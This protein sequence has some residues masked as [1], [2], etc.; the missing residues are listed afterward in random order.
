[1]AYTP[2]KLS[3][4]EFLS[5]SLDDQF[6]LLGYYNQEPDKYT[7]Y[8]ANLLPWNLYKTIASTHPQIPYIKSLWQSNIGANDTT[9]VIN[10]NENNSARTIRAKEIIKDKVYHKLFTEL[11]YSSL[12]RQIINEIIECGSVIAWFNDEDKPVLHSI[13]EFNVYWDRVNK[14]ARYAWK[15]DGGEVPGFTDLKHGVEIWHIKDPAFENWIVPPSRIDCAFM[16]IL[17][18]NHGFRANNNIF[19]NGVIGPVLLNFKQEAIQLFKEAPEKKG[20]KN[21]IQRK[22]DEFNDMFAGVKKSFRI[23][24]IP[25]LESAI[26][27]GKNNRDMQ[28]KELLKELTPERIAWA[29]S[30]TLIDFGTGG[31]TTDN[32]TKNLDFALYDKIGRAIEENLDA[33]RNKWL[34]PHY[35]YPVSANLY[36]HYNPPADPDKLN[37][38]ASAREDYK[39]NTITV[40]EFRDTVGLEPLPGGD[41][42]YSEWTG[43][44]NQK[45]TAQLKENNQNEDNSNQKS[46]SLGFF[47]KNTNFAAKTPTEKA[48]ESDLFTG[49]SKKKGFLRRWQTAVEKWGKAYISTIKD[50]ESAEQIIANLSTD[51]PKVET[52]YSFPTLKKDLLKF[53]GLALEGVQK[54]KRTNFKLAKYFDGEYPDQVIKA[55]ENR[56]MWLLK[57]GDDIPE[58][59]LE[60]LPDDYRSYKGIDAEISRQISKLVADNATESVAKILELLKAKF[61]ELSEIKAEQIAYTEVAEAVEG[62]RSIMYQQEFEGG[63]KEWLTGFYDVCPVCEAN[64]KEGRIPITALF[65][66]GHPRPT[67]HPKCGCTC[68]YYPAK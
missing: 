48:V 16:A 65:S 27:L 66:S 23:G 25:L 53:A 11:E 9:V 14:R 3:V 41:V 32:N 43:S 67:A 5:G 47:A 42:F 29:Y 62:T 44:L 64:S 8:N 57:G 39:F 31:S 7:P 50:Y 56:V 18:E 34:L 45:S 26:E 21:F 37:K 35:N 68:L 2:A 46:N 51:S 13:S 60:L 12:E 15:Q 19:S 1:M 30:T 38:V 28:F 54:D 22:I 4:E 59:N 52:F 17:L 49:N 55:I 6:K 10:I 33:M 24:S 63:Q 36:V 58:E 61:S 20:G 40:N